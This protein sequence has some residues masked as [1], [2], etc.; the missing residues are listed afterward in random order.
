[1]RS[2]YHNHTYR[3]GHACGTEEEY[4]KKAISEGI[5]NLG[6][7][8]HTP[9][10]LRE[11]YTSYCRM[12]TDEIDDYCQ[13]LLR[14]REKYKGYINIHIGFETEYYKRYF[15][16]LISLYRKHPIEYIIYA[17]HF[18]GN[19]GDDD[20]TFCAFDRTE[21]KS[22]LT[23]YV[24]NALEAIGTGRFSMIAHPDMVNFVGDTDFYRQESE[25][26]IRGANA[27]GIPLEINLYGMRDG[28]NYPN[29]E[30]WSIAGRLGAVATLGFDSHH[31]KHVADENEIINGLRFADRYGIEIVDQIKLIDPKR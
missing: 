26:L 12:R 4:I 19:E 6:F 20:G 13:T 1:M 15:D 30:F 10:P 28:R 25:R 2:N 16:S 31:V 21:D 24:D 18:I 7:S 29:P 9:Y 22:R 5:Y 17:G 8:D 3:C 14:L 11:G 23:A 27:A